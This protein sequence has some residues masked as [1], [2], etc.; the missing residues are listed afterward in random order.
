MTGATND[1]IHAA[2]GGGALL[3]IGENEV[4]LRN[5]VWSNQLA[6]PDGPPAWTYTR[7]S[8]FRIFF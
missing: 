3:V 1:L 4:R 7:T 5:A 2:S 6:Q 8:A